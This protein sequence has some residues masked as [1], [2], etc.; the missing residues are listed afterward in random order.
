MKA[1]PLAAPIPPAPT[2]ELAAILAAAL[3]RVLKAGRSATPEY[4]PISSL[5]RVG[6]VGLIVPTGLPSPRTENRE[7]MKCR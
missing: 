1:D 2:S 7:H 3:I 5:E 6:D 4:R